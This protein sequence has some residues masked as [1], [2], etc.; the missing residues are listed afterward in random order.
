MTLDSTSVHPDHLLVVQLHQHPP[1]PS[2]SKAALG[3]S[4]ATQGARDFS[5]FL[6]VTAVPLTLR[7]SQSHS[8]S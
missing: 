5:S 6:T 8:M 7:R 2:L 1:L 4:F 3:T